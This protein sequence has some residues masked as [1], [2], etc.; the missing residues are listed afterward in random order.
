MFD[1]FLMCERFGGIQ[2]DEDEVARASGGNDLTASA[3]AFGGSFNDSREV[4]DLDPSSLVCDAINNDVFDVV[5][6]RE[7]EFVIF[8][9]GRQ[10][11]NLDLM[12]FQKQ[13]NCDDV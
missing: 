5:S 7:R 2:N 4:E 9:Q 6:F 13:M 12:P 8:L 10:E 11:W 1:D 3:F